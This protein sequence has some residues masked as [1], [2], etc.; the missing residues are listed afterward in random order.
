ML[1]ISK[2]GNIKFGGTE[3]GLPMQYSSLFVT[4]TSKNGE[5]NFEHFEGYEKGLDSLNVMLPFVEDLNDSFNVGLISF[6]LINETIKYY[7]KVIEDLVYLFPLQPNMKNPT[8]PY[9]VI[10]LGKA[11]EWT[12]KLDLKQ[13]ALL[14]TYLPKENSFDFVGG[15]LGTFLFKTSSAHSIAEI[16][17]TLHLMSGIDKNVLRMVD[18]KLEVHTKLVKMGDIEEVTYVRLLPPSVDKIMCAEQLKH[19]AGANYLETIEKNI[20]DSRK[21]SIEEAVSIEE[22]EKVI[23]SKISFKLDSND[24]FEISV[25]NNVKTKEKS[26]VSEES[27]VD[28]D[29]LSTEYK[30]PAPLLTS[31]VTKV[32]KDKAREVIE[33]KK[34]VVAD[35]IKYIASSSESTIDKK[36][37]NEEV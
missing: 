23:G 12:D 36:I 8:V 1:N 14:Y 19:S 29:N 21:K 35:I 6:I 2:M 7:A 27:K 11:E 16:Q 3:N 33:E 9:P 25:N 28:I 31:L 13:R 20:S 26:E 32:G 34:G 18:F 17:N 15:A 22:A 5:E 24:G 37:N 30:L 4:K 10:K